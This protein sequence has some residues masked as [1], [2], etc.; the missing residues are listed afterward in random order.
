MIYSEE[1]IKNWFKVMKEKYPNSNTFNHLVS[2]EFMMFNRCS[3]DQLKDIKKEI[4]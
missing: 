3:F 1:E 2:I 4:K